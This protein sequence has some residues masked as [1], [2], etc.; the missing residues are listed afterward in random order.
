MLKSAVFEGSLSVH[1]RPA[2]DLIGSV[3]PVSVRDD[4]ELLSCVDRAVRNQS[5]FTAGIN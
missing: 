2:A 5:L 3:G 1:C 4:M